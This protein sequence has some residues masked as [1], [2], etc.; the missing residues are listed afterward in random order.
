MKDMSKVVIKPPNKE[1][2][3]CPK[4]FL[5]LALFYDTWKPLENEKFIKGECETTSTCTDPDY[6]GMGL[7]YIVYLKY[8][9]DAYMRGVKHIFDIYYNIVSY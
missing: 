9:E 4:E 3:T 1:E 6:Q 8:L 2:I 5:K 7:A